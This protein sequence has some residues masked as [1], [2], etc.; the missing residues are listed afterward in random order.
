MNSSPFSR[1]RFSAALALLAC[2]LAAGPL[3]RAQT[4]LDDFSA[5]L[6]DTSYTFKAGDDTTWH[7]ADGTL[8]PV[9][10]SAADYHAW[11]W[12]GGQA[13]VNVGDSFSIDLQVAPS[14]GAHNGGLAVWTSSAAN[15]NPATDR[16][17]EPRL[18]YDSGVFS[19]V[20][21]FNN[22]D[23]YTITTLDAAPVGFTTLAITL[24][25][26][27]ADSS[28]LTAVLSGTGFTTLQHDYTFNFTGAM[29]VG[30]SSYLA[31]A[32]NVAFDNLAYSTSTSAIPEPSTYAAIFGACALGLAAWRRR[33][34]TVPTH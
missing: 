19:F 3:A 13:L 17:F 5:N 27:T 23:G 9:H 6:H 4:V 25:G 10:S 7:V 18:G 14:G 33:T 11:I 12:S 32:G 30:P 8:Q 31:D 20:S 16:V 15:T 29:F 21:E 22:V 28:T 34:T 24:S 26:R 2:G 1:F